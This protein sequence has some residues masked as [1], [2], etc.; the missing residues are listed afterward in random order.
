[1]GNLVA[2]IVKLEAKRLNKLRS[3]LLPPNSTCALLLK[4]G[5]TS[6][7]QDIFTVVNWYNI[8]DKYKEVTYV[9]VATLDN[10]FEEKLLIASDL[11]INNRVYEINKRDITP[12][13]GDNGFW[14]ISCNRT[15]FIYT[16]PVTP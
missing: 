2:K 13:N 1:M 5:F 3:K 7:Y 8:Y 10:S 12:P 4:V 6:E 9:Q 15:E 14:N 11:H 16:A